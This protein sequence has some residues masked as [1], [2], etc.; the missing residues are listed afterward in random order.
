[1]P[2]ISYGD[3]GLSTG[4]AMAK[5]IAKPPLLVGKGSPLLRLHSYSSHRLKQRV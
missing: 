4:C 1:M 2:V 3:E 5:K